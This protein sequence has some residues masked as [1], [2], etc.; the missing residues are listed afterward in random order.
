MSTT[1]EAVGMGGDGAGWCGEW[2][3]MSGADIVG[4]SRAAWAERRC[5]FPWVSYRESRNPTVPL[6]AVALSRCK[7][8]AKGRGNYFLTPESGSNGLG[9][10]PVILSAND[11]CRLCQRQEARY[12]RQPELQF[13]NDVNLLAFRGTS[14]RGIQASLRHHSSQRIHA[15]YSRHEYH[16]L[17]TQ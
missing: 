3:I 8:S 14:I 12:T 6:H 16:I 5:C 1:F 15:L 17:P 11:P 9:V 7:T 2:S 10:C 13:F 4:G